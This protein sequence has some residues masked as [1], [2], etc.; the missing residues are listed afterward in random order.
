MICYI[1]QT[2]HPLK[3]ISLKFSF[4]DF[5]GYS[6]DDNTYNHLTYTEN[7]RDNSGCEIIR[8]L[9]KNTIPISFTLNKS[10]RVHFFKEMDGKSN[11]TV[12]VAEKTYPYLKCSKYSAINSNKDSEIIFEDGYEIKTERFNLFDIEVN[13]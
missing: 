12:T 1:K 13:H 6:S 7:K 11:G 5:V 10:I 4:T 3:P 9:V 8:R 2:V